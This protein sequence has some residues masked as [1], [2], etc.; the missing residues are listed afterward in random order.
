MARQPSVIVGAGVV[1]CALAQRLAAEGK[2]PVVLEA[3][4]RIAEGVTSRNSGVIHAGLYYPPGSLKAESCIR[5]NELL[6]E[7]CLARG[8]PHKKTGK[9]VV[10]SEK[11][12]IDDLRWLME[13]ANASGVRALRW[14]STPAIP[15][16]TA[17]AAVFVPST[18]I[19]DPYCL[20][21][22]L[23]A[24]AEQK[25]AFF[26]MESRVTSIEALSGGGVRIETSRGV[27]ETDLLF[28][29]AGLQTDEILRAGGIMCPK[30]YP[31]RGD[32]FR[33][34]RKGPWP[35]L[36]YPAKNKNT[37]GL[38]VHLTMDLSGSFRLGP[39]VTLAASKE[40]FSTPEGAALEA[41]AAAF[42]AS[43]RK[44]L[45]GVQEG[46][47]MY[48]SCGIRPKLRGPN[49]LTEK[50]FHLDSPIPGVVVLAGIESPGLTAS[51]DLAERAARLVR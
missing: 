9:W 44:Y 38:G 6:Y 40:D 50:D 23:Q 2:A 29:A 8:V 1:G 14:E 33:M 35:P 10:A 42:F 5:G 13:N 37:A 18:G 48:D 39:D 30:I 32:Y 11:S 34:R 24:A 19:V 16:I 45:Q 21:Q 46:D 47:L 31:W 4:P 28:V 27:I 43:A 20:S 22:S 49:D 36:V 12:Q 41:K 15:G 26:A 7:W 51:L 17:E 25:G 3:G